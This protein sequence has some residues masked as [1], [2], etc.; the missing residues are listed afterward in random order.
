MKDQIKMTI[1]FLIFIL[2]ISCNVEDKSKRFSLLKANRTGVKFENLLKK[3]EQFNV[4]E[5]G[6]MYN[7]GGVSVGDLN[8]DALPESTL[9]EIWSA[10]IYI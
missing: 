5:Y 10:A 3:T 9:L 4:F 6:Y 8:N 1:M 7:G 2:H